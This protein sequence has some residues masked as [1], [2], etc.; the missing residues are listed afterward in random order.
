MTRRT[1]LAALALAALSATRLVA[2]PMP[3][4]TA[5]D[6][7]ARATPPNVG[8]GAVY[9]TLTSRADD[10]LVGAATAVAAQAEL[11]EMK[12]VNNVMQMRPLDGLDLPAGQAVALKPGG[13]HI[14]LEG[15]KAP[16]KQGGTVALRLT[17]VHAPP[18][19]VTATVQPIGAAGPQAAGTMSHDMKG[20]PGMTMGK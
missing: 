14:M 17:F 10:R 1:I 6:A 13:Y 3:S 7:W 20:M 9:L 11:H 15:L 19:D 5:Q 2:Q 12:M 4:V 8:T 18:L 16:L